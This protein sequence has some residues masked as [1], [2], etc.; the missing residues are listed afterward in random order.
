MPVNNVLNVPTYKFV[1]SKYLLFWRARP[2]QPLV[3]DKEY[4]GSPPPL[5]SPARPV[6]P[7]QWG[8]SCLVKSGHWPPHSGRIKFF[9]SS[10]YLPACWCFKMWT[11]NNQLQQLGANP[12]FPRLMGTAT[13][14]RPNVV[15]IKRILDLKS[16][17]I[18]QNIKVVVCDRDIFVELVSDWAARQE[19]T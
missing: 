3:V 12:L 19:L 8:G 4:F 17:L 15:S 13:Q 9:A 14:K 7:R 18:A 1:I 2:C 11:E 16:Y 10:K 5:L 6:T